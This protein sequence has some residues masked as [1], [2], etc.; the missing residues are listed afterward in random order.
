MSTDVPTGKNIF[1]YVRYVQLDE[2]ELY[3]FGYK[4]HQLRYY[5]DGHVHEM[6]DVPGYEFLDFSPSLEPRMDKIKICERVC[7]KLLSK[8][9]KQCLDDMPNQICNMRTRVQ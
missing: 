5:K 3:T 7:H 8:I 1:D 9:Q 6:C 4:Q 2:I